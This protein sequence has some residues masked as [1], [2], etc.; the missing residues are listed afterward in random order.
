MKFM[1]KAMIFILLFFGGCEGKLPPLPPIDFP[2]KDLEWLIITG[3]YTLE[4]P[5]RVKEA[6]DAHFPIERLEGES[7]EDYIKRNSY[8]LKRGDERFKYSQ[9]LYCYNKRDPRDKTE[10]SFP[11]LKARLYDK[12]GNILEEDFLRFNPEYIHRDYRSFSV[13][14]PYHNEGHRLKITKELKGKETE[15]FMDI[16]VRSKAYLISESIRNRGEESSEVDFQYKE[17]MKCHG[18]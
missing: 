9:I 3:R 13:H 15:V 17:G 14:I 10:A 2:E 18:R 5:E 11:Y 1:K 6:I 16:P 12:E 4:N 7:R 8:L